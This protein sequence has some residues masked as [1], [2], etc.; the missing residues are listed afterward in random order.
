M[1]YDYIIPRLEYDYVIHRLLVC[2]HST[3]TEDISCLRE[4]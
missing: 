1:Q 4:I 2:Y 3:I